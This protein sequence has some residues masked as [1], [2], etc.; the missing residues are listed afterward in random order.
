MRSYFRGIALDFEAREMD[1]PQDIQ[2]YCRKKYMECLQCMQCVYTTEETEEDTDIGS[3]TYHG[4]NSFSWF[5]WCF[6]W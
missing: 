5:P 2:Q 6:V 4:T 1:N 3:D